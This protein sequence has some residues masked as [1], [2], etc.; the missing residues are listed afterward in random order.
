MKF[1]SFYKASQIQEDIWAPERLG[2]TSEI[3]PKPASLVFLSGKSQSWT[4]G[5]GSVGLLAFAFGEKWGWWKRRYI[6]IPDVATR[7]SAQ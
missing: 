2:T 5:L 3:L 4:H 6:S 7:G 1:T